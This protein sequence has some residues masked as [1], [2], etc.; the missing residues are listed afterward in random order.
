MSQ[1]WRKHGTKK[2]E[3]AGLDRDVATFMAEKGDQMD[4]G[5]S[6]IKGHVE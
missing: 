4:G 2:G 6:S 1:W 3:T 5:R